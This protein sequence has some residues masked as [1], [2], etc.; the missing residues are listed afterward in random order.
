MLKWLL[1]L[2]LVGALGAA[3]T[4]P[5]E[6]SF[7]ASLRAQLVTALINEPVDGKEAG[8]ALALMT[9]RLDPSACADLVRAGIETSFEDRTLYSVFHLEGFG[10]QASCIGLFTRITCPG[11]ITEQ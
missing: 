5:D 4:V 9:C 7:E 2:C 1:G 3:F 10:R 8:T 11:G 6:P